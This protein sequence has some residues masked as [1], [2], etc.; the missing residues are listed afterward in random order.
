M[1]KQVSKAPEIGTVLV[2]SDFS[3]RLPCFFRT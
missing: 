2:A 1:E 3:I